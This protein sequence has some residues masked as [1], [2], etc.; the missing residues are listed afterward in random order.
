ME[1]SYYRDMHRNYL[2]I[3]CNDPGGKNTHYQYR[4]LTVNKAPSLLGCEIRKIDGDYYL[5][6]DITSRQSLRNMYH[7]RTIGSLAVRSLLYAVAAAGE[8]LGTY[9]LDDDRILL[10]PEMIYYD[11]GSDRYY[12]VYY[13]ET[14][15]QQGSV[16]LMSFLAEREDLTDTE[17]AYVLYHLREM[18]DSPNFR[19]NKAV[20]DREY[21]IETEVM[22]ENGQMLIQE[23]ENN[24]RDYIHELAEEFHDEHGYHEEAKP[25]E[26][27]AGATPEQN[28]AIRYIFTA[29]VLLVLAVIPEL[30]LQHILFPSLNLDSFRLQIRAGVLTLLVLAVILVIYSM[31]L[32]IRD[33]K[34]R[35]I[36]EEL[37]QAARS[38][39]A[40]V[41][42]EEFPDF[43]RPVPGS[44]REGYN[45]PAGLRGDSPVS[46][47]PVYEETVKKIP[48]VQNKLYG[49]GSARSYRIDLNELPCTVGKLRGFADIILPDSSVSGL[50]VRFEGDGE[51]VIMT[52]LNSISGTWLNGER[53]NPQQ[54][55]QIIPGDEIWIGNLSFV[56]R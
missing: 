46:E 41:P 45:S 26:S 42:A 38:A 3:H 18:A 5:Y 6:Y 51:R 20:L 56:Y 15:S 25:D 39:A 2:V 48:E 37:R 4:M 53:L 10:T 33:R 47:E 14:D 13:P 43:V 17:Y 11:Y 21:G 55:Q 23:E 40:N 34:E 36:Q 54:T 31:F 7:S 28:G 22:A 12:F 30:M 50:H 1:Y 27:P 32:M 19:I 35:K 29:S 9:L 49:S 16:E 44:V 24:S 52:D 8:E